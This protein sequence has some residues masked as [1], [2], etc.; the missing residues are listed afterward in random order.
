MRSSQ[1]YQHTSRR[2]LTALAREHH[3]GYNP[4]HGADP[5]GA[6]TPTGRGGTS[7][8]SAPADLSGA[9]AAILAGD[10]RAS[11]P[12]GALAELVATLRAA[13]RL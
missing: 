11:L 8:G 6:P 9:V 2:V 3:T 13:D 12:D 1:G 10:D 7:G 4:R 5:A